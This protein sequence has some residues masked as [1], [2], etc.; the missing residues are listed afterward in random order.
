MGFRFRKSFKIAP[1]IRLNLSKSGIGA[2]VGVKGF[3]VTKRADGRMQRTTSIP[4]T[5]VSYV[6]TSSGSSSRNDEAV[7]SEP[8]PRKTTT[9][10]TCGH[11]YTIGKANF[12]SQCGQSLVA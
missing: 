1:G 12:C 4:G 7:V 11:R 5:G 9:C 8:T 2:S 6:T 3:R 10:P